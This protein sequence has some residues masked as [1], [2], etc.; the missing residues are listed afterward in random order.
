MRQLITVS[1]PAGNATRA[2]CGRDHNKV[3]GITSS[4]HGL[5]RTV[6]PHLRVV[7]VA[8]RVQSPT[9]SQSSDLSADSLGHVHNAMDT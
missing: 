7:L 8:S 4:P 9:A 2:H 5:P 1:T 3:A 6:I